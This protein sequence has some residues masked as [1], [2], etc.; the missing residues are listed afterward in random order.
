MDKGDLIV[1]QQKVTVLRAEGKYQE[2]I[3]NCYNLLES[4]MQLKDYKSVLTAYINLAASY[5]CIG[6]IEVAFNKLEAHEEICDI[7]G[8][9]NDILNNYNIL[10]L[11]HDYNKDYYKAK[12]TLKKSIELGKKLKRYNIVSNGYS[13]YSHI[14]IL[15]EDYV[16]ALEKSTLGLEMAKL[17]EPNT[18]ILEFRVKLNIAKA[19]IGL[20]DF[21][22]SKSMIDEMIN[23]PLLDSFIREKSQCY[24]LQGYW[25]SKQ[26]LNREAFKSFT[27]AKNLVETYND[28]YLMKTI[29]E[30]RCSLC[31]LMNDIQLGYQVQKE[32]ISLLNEISSRELALT[33]LKLEIKRSMSSLEKKANTDY[34]TGIYNRNY[35]ENTVNDW[36]KQAKEQ[37]ERIA[38][39]V[40]DIDEF[41]FI[42]DIYGHVFGDEVI[43]Q[44]SKVCSNVIR[45]SDLIGRYGGDEFVII[46]KKASYEDAKQKAEQILEAVRNLRIE[47]DGMSILITISIGVA[48]NLDSAATNFNELF[49]A[50]DVR[51]YK[52]KYYGKNQVCIAN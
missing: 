8:D 9:E 38:C 50:A 19:Y 25:Y 45:E 26:G 20:K 49:N 3:E 18:P 14:C 22:T 39:I 7:H 44:V 48:D 31:E 15:E 21:D 23:N 41:K 27:V 2:A 29:Q 4:G 34:L 12:E 16:K 6:D 51:M 5:Y 46:L 40:F 10:F 33:A 42:N 1:L 24:D 37:N 11:L 17:H 32:Y 13:N 47:N 43:K 36:L 52:A 28:V 30:E 35:L